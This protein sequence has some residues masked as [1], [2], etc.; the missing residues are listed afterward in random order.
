MKPEVKR[1]L[2][3]IIAAKAAESRA[4]LL[5]HV[6]RAKWNRA[7]RRELASA[8]AAPRSNRLDS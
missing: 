8:A 4:P 2:L 1:Y 7:M 3:G 6:N 5:E